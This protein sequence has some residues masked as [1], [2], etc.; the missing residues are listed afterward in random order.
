MAGTALTSAV[1]AQIFCCRQALVDL[2]AACT[3]V[4]GDVAITAD[5]LVAIN[6]ALALGLAIC[7]AKDKK[8]LM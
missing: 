8:V 6:G 3:I 4:T 2:Q 1:F 7:A 5:T